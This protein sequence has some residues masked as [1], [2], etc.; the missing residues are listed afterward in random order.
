MRDILRLSLILGLVGIVSAVL[1][2]AAHNVTEP[3]ILERRASDYRDALE[4]FFPGFDSF[5]TEELDEGQFDLI[6][7]QEG[8]LMGIMATVTASGYD[9]DIL[10]NLA[11]DEEGRIIGMKIVSH[12]ETPGIGDVIER[13][14]FQE[15]FEG[16]S[17]EDPIT[18]GDDVEIVTGATVSAAAMINSIRQTTEVVAVNFL[19]V[20][21][22]E[23]D[24]AEVPDGTYQGAAQGF[25]G[26][27]EV[28][29]EVS[30]GE[31]VG[32]EVLEHEE[33]AT[34]FV[35]AYPLIPERIIEEQT[36]DIDTQTG[37][38]ASAAGIVNAVEN[39]LLQAL[40]LEDEVEEEPVEEEP[41][42]VDIGAVPDGSYQGS[43]E[44]FFAPIV[45]E[46]EVADGEIVSI[47]IVEHEE[48]PEYFR[49]V[50]PAIP[51]QII[52]EQHFDIDLETGATG[53]ARGIVN[54]ILDAL[55]GALNNG[56]GGEEN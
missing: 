47:E 16:K 24:F 26:P 22:V 28:E 54:A 48:T 36:L 9:G 3:I 10:Y 13:D 11:L 25:I 50:N 27:I 1:L 41:V 40:G 44:G 42:D 14:N 19:D 21:V 18:A 8:D 15:Q 53:S 6:Y 55:S 46:V 45:V 7:D 5:E 12:T 52:E 4:N 32:I 38:T 37:A 31:V 56:G 35:E 30:G 34:Y 23:I 17:Y 33:T 49:E 39:A 51:E 2:T 29:V 20:E 43:A